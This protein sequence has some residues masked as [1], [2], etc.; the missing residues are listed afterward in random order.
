MREGRG[1]GERSTWTENADADKPAARH[2]C[3]LYIKFLIHELK[4]PLLFISQLFL[5]TGVE[6]VVV[7]GVCAYLWSR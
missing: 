4:Y 3:L 2:T 7:M 6:I 1:N 5:T